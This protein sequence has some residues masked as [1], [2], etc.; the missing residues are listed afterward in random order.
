MIRRGVALL[1]LVVLISLHL[2]LYGQTFAMKGKLG[3]EARVNY[4]LP[5]ELTRATALDFQG[6]AADFQLLQ[7]IF[8]IG[9]KL[10]RQV[11]VTDNE[12]DYFIRIIKAVTKLDPY[13]YDTYHLATGILTWGVGRFQEA[14]EILETA[15]QFNPNDYRFPYQIGFIHFYFLKDAKK[16][17]QYL[18]LASKLPGAPPFLASLAARLAYYKG[19][20]DF[21]IKLLEHMLVDERSPE[22]RKYYQKR[23][24]ALQGALALEK[25]VQEYKKTY[26]RLPTSLQELLTANVLSELPRDP[27]GGE[28]TLVENGRIYSTSRFTDMREQDSKKNETVKE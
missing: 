7:G 20:Y 23:L 16:G 6:L 19:N 22:I 4:V 14:I 13:F 17:A 11:L 15:R 12:W 21:S 3:N 8:F 24:D 5:A 27:Y 10:E 2:F 28:Y 9:E 1:V 26:L 25:A 18:A